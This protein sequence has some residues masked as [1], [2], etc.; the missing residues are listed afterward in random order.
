MRAACSISLWLGHHA[1]AADDSARCN[2]CTQASLQ[3][4]TVRAGTSARKQARACYLCKGTLA[5]GEPGPVCDVLLQGRLGP[6]RL[7]HC[8]RLIGAAERA[9]S[10]AATRALDRV[11]FGAPLAAQVCAEACRGADC[12]R[13]MRWL[14]GYCARFV[15][16]L[17]DCLVRCPCAWPA[18]AAAFSVR[19]LGCLQGCA[20]FFHNVFLCADV[21]WCSWF[22][23]LVSVSAVCLCL[24]GGLR[25]VLARQRVALEGARL[26]VLNASHALDRC[27]ATLR[28]D[29]I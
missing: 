8:M 28:P 7:H 10:L 11:A 26:L 3:L 29:Q 22:S 19:P 13:C 23:V 5:A 6:G 20:P 27:V 15:R 25:E 1:V 9:L 17:A 2:I 16:V 4:M 18:S 24:Q 12:V 21:A 14:S